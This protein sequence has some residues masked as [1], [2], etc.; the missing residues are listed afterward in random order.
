MFFLH[1][2]YESQP[3]CTVVICCSHFGFSGRP[4]SF[5]IFLS[6]SVQIAMYHV[7]RRSKAT[8]RSRALIGSYV[9]T[10]ASQ[11]FDQRSVSQEVERESGTLWE[12][13]I[14]RSALVLNFVKEKLSGQLFVKRSFFLVFLV[15]L[16][17]LL[18]SYLVIIS[19]FLLS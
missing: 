18:L 17:L 5:G 1:I 13:D 6:C 11:S 4:I 10:L 19:F 3:H 7:T 15:I 9:P 2:I 8:R 14:L 16:F 12:T